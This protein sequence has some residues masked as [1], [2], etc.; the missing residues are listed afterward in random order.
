MQR[1]VTGP[2]HRFLAVVP[3]QLAP[4]C[5][6]ELLQLG[7]KGTKITEAGV[8]FEGKLRDAYAANLW[9]RTAGRVVC[10]MDSFRAGTEEELLHKTAAR[11]WELW[12]NPLIPLKVSAFVEKSRVSHEGLVKE[13]VVNGIHKRMRDLGFP[14][15]RP[16]GD[17]DPKSVQ[18]LWVHLRNNHCLI[19]L[20]TSG[21]HLHERG[22][23]KV[24]GGA[25]LRET[26]AAAILLRSGW[27]GE[28]PLLDGMCG[29]GTF[30]IEAAC[31]SRRIPPGLGRRFLFEMWPS[32][33]EKTWN[34]LKRSASGAERDA[35][36]GPLMALDVDSTA[37]ELAIQ[38][39]REAGVSDHI[40]FESLDFFRFEPARF[41][42]N[43]GLV[44]LNPP[45]GKR[46]KVNSQKFYS[47][48]GTHLREH[49]KGWRAAVLAPDRTA[50]ARLNLPSA[51]TWPVM[52]G[53]LKVM[54][55]LGVV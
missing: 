2:A 8:E 53:G 49:F 21:P 46:L 14:L 40:R 16:A 6:D 5:R 25:P 26:L 13:L 4:L 1:H 47:R 23:R 36:V 7:M 24:H 19:S 48:I 41:N 22:Y 44:V 55:V 37:I 27:S 3:P 11:P 52:H 35:P 28:M 43:P 30:V 45:Y 9:L 10:L 38:N 42:L 18:R 39:A 29:A 54:V 15:S 20:D 50:A 12:L 33:Q 34:Y 31:I 51:E 32:F 17:T